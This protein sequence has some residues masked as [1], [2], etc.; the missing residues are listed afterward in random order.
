MLCRFLAVCPSA[1]ATHVPTWLRKNLP[2]S[3]AIQD[4]TG[5]YCVLGLMGP[6]ARELLQVLTQT[7]LENS[8]FPYGT[9]Q[10][11]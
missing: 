8:A 1:Q 2:S 10:V 4:K 11:K 6:K 9:G 5:Q 3:I 7:S